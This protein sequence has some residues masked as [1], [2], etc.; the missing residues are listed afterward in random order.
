MCAG[1]FGF[2]NI[3]AVLRE[4]ERTK[5]V[6]PVCCFTCS[7][8]LTICFSSE[9]HMSLQFCVCAKLMLLLWCCCCHSCCRVFV[10]ACNTRRSAQKAF[11]PPATCAQP[12]ST[13]KKCVFVWKIKKKLKVFIFTAASRGKRANRRSQAHEICKNNNLHSLFFPL[14]GVTLFGNG[15]F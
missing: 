5:V 12:S 1:L 4:N 10:V 3:F 13:L 2:C 15:G 8:P 7:T 11:E 6:R 14:F 9:R